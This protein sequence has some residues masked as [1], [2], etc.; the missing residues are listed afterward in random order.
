MTSF[1][2]GDAATVYSSPFLGWKYERAFLSRSFAATGLIG[3]LGAL[4]GRQDGSSAGLIR[5][6][7]VD[8]LPAQ[9]A[10]NCLSLVFATGKSDDRLSCGTRQL[11][12]S[13][14]FLDGNTNEFSHLA[15]CP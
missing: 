4:F 3:A 13:H 1:L 11:Y 2:A 6:K 8:P 14:P 10:E 5:D 12:A 7:S 9:R 15:K